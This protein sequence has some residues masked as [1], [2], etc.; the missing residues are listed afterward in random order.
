V[1]LQASLG[2]NAYRFSIEWARIEPRA[3]AIDHA[4]VDEYRR[5]LGALRDARIEPF[6]TLHHFTL[7]KWLAD[8]GG[9]L[10][11]DFAQRFARFAGIA[12]NA[13]GDL[14]RSW[15]TI[16]E[17]NVLAAQAYLLGVWPPALRSPIAAVR[18][19][20]RLL[21]AHTAAYRTLKDARPDASVGLA[22]HLRVV[23]PERA[24]LRDRVAASTFR[25]VFNDA[26]A[27]A[28][29]RAGTQDFFGINYYTRDVVR[30]APGNVA[31]GFVHRGVPKGAEVSDLGWEVY[32]E[33]LGQLVRAWGRRSGL[34]V[35][36]MENGIADA[37]DAKRASFVVRH[38]AE[39]AR[40]M[41]EGIDV[42]GYFHWSLLDNFEW[43]DGY[44]PRF[45]LV[46]VDYATQERRVRDSARV[47]AR[48][49]RE[50]SVAL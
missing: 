10:A 39:L 41:D 36:V 28:V 25:R 15:I 1:A 14:C 34:P 3:G 35:Y 16:N 27:E 19:H 12:A 18:A 23:Q 5:L 24:R 26:F 38:L 45:G 37:S 17:P 30:F 4:A 31:E 50:R 40:A 47:Y 46:E 29:C 2:M 33:G 21:E 13:L 49:A 6:V 48:I 32:P 11:R 42:R 9:V 8:D 22:H 7:P 20:G 43:A 44:E